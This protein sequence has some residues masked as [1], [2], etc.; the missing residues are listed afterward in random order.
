MSTQHAELTPKSN[1]TL[2]LLTSWAKVARARQARY[3]QDRHNLEMLE[4]ARKGQ[5]TFD[6][7]VT[8]YATAHGISR[9]AVVDQVTA[10]TYEEAGR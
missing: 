5:E 2:C 7:L 6:R 9:R 3:G 8:D 10:I 4:Q 1:V